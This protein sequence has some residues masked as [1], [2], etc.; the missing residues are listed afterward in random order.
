MVLTGVG[1][2]NCLFS[3]QGKCSSMF[4]VGSIRDLAIGRF[5][6]FVS[7]DLSS[8]KHVLSVCTRVIKSFGLLRFSGSG[9]VQQTGST[10]LL[11]IPLTL[12]AVWVSESDMLASSAHTSS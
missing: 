8:F 3:L 9:A 2:C 10:W 7:D 5:V 12:V 6:V 4:S 11:F 1:N